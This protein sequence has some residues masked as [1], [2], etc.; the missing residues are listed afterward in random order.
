MKFTD[1]MAKWI[2]LFFGSLVFTVVGLLI[3]YLTCQ[4]STLTCRKA[5]GKP[6]CQYTVSLLEQYTI[7]DLAIQDLKSASV[8]ESC[9]DDCTYRVVLT[10]GYGTQAF[11]DSSDSDRSGKEQKANQINTYLNS[12]DTSTLVVKDGGGFW[13]IFP[14]IFIFAGVW[15]GVRLVVDVIRSLISQR[16][17]ELE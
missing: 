7:K 4:V 16:Q 14:L 2:G 13:I 12:D 9:S 6:V 17:S 11:T 3:F 8:E 5:D 10:T 15:M 1:Q